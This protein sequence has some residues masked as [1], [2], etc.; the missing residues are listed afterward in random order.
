MKNKKITYRNPVS[1]SK[2]VVSDY[3]KEQF[4]ELCQKAGEPYR[5]YWFF[6]NYIN[7]WFKSKKTKFWTP[8]RGKSETLDNIIKEDSNI[9]FLD[10][11]DYPAGI[12]YKPHIEIFNFHTMKIASRYFETFDEAKAFAENIIKDYNLDLIIIED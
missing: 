4:F 3:K 10:N 1:I 2:I 11:E 6:D 5:F 9:V 8:L 7:L 12:Y